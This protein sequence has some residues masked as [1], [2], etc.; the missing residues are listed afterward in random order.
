[1]NKKSGILKNLNS[2]KIEYKTWINTQYV[3]MYFQPRQLSL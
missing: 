2:G 1:M 3:K